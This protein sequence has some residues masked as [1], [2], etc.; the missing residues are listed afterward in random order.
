MQQVVV[1]THSPIIARQRVGIHGQTTMDDKVAPIA[2][3]TLISE[4]NQVAIP[5]FIPLGGLA[6]SP[7]QWQGGR[8]HGSWLYPFTQLNIH[9][10]EYF[11]LVHAQSNASRYP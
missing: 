11:S 4:K 3:N 5:A 8:A 9:R 2:L 10:V 1:L 7:G 6:L